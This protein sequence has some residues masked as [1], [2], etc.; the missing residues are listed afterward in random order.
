MN[1]NQLIIERLT[2]LTNCYRQDPKLKFK[3]RAFN[4]ALVNIKNCD[5]QI[6]NGKHAKDEIPNIGDG[7]AK[8]IDEILNS[9]TLIEL[10]K[11]K[12]EQEKAKKVKLTPDEQLKKQL[13]QEK[14]K[15]I[16]TLCTVT[17]IGQK[18]AGDLYKLGIK[19]VEQLRVAIKEGK[20]KSTHHIDIGLK[21]Y[22]EITQRIPRGEII[23]ME[24]I[25]KDCLDN[26]LCTYKFSICGSYRRG[27]ETCGDID[28][29]ITDTAP[30]KSGANLPK[31]VE[32]LRETGFLI[33]D[34]T[35]GGFK[36]YMGVC[37][38]SKRS[39]PR[40]IDIRWVDYSQF[41][42]ALIYFTGSKIFNI[43]IR[44]KAIQKGYSL[45]EYGFK[46]KKSGK[47]ITVDSE[48]ELFDILDL[49][50]VKPTDRDLH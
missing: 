48:E 25:L 13:N 45:S 26:L 35:I 19:T 3:V 31:Y 20:I 29:L 37:Q 36:K 5:C 47:V 42:A 16:E 4:C 14:E 40:R 21:Y 43:N 30:K 23:V 24:K 17:G 46:E 2:E 18:R 15:V 32:M 7:I 44:N 12:K 50:Y 27:C 10:D 49:E 11:F 41:Y 34:L 28:V 33:D 38:L 8:R 39:I 1:N 22:E 9:G 6:R